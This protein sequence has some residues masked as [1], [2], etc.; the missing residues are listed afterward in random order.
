[1]AF[2]GSDLLAKV[3]DHI[4]E[5]SANYWS[6]AELYRKIDSAHRALWAKII[7]LRKDYFKSSFTF[8][9]TAG[10]YSYAAGSGGVPTDIWR[11]L[12]M[13]TTTSGRQDLMWDAGN[14]TSRGFIDGLNSEVPVYNP[15]SMKYALR[16][17][18]ELWVSP[19]PQESVSAQV[20]YIPRPTAISAAGSTF[21]VPDE[22]MNW[23]EYMATADALNKGPVGDPASWL[24]KAGAAWREIAEALD[25]PRVD[26]GAD[27][28]EGMFED[29]G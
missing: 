10:T 25:T 9:T 15:F 20:D 24:A 22:F 7:S 13:R 19:L 29:V 6:N 3:R 4:D 17:Q 16:S 1:M 2:V 11:I 5:P 27:V 23:V 12:S 26:Q 28:V 8:T 18:N 14:P 21:L